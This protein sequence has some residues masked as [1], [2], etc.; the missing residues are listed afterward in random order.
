MTYKLVDILNE[1]R[2]RNSDVESHIENIFNIK[3]GREFNGELV[4]FDF[5]P[6]D[7]PL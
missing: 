1:L 3:L 7:I 2:G 6:P 5:Y 4:A